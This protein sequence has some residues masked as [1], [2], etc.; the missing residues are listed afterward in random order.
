M[1][2]RSRKAITRNETVADLRFETK[3]WAAAD[4][5]RDTLLAK[6]ISG[7]V[8]GWEAVRMTKEAAT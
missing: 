5:L 2:K 3:L 6:L 4:S 7:E 1:A 8:R